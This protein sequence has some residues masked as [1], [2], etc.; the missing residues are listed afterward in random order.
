MDLDHI[1][2]IFFAKPERI[3]SR[4][5]SNFS[6]VLNLL[7]S[8]TPDEIR[9]I[10]DRSLANYQ[11]RKKQGKTSLWKEFTRHL[12]FLKAEG[13]VDE[14]NRLTEDGTWAS[15]LRLDQPLLIAQCLREDT[16]PRD[17][18]A[19]LAAVIAPFA[20]D[21]SSFATISRSSLPKRLKKAYGLCLSGFRI[22]LAK[23]WRMRDSR[24]RL[25]PSGDA[26]CDL[27]LGPGMDWTGLFSDRG[28]RMAILAMLISRT[29]DSLH[30]IASLTE[31][32]PQV[33]ARA[34]AARTAIPEIRSCLIDL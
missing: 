18:E 8:H 21:R 22:P 15:Q 11:Y 7:L 29:A 14:Q 17:S 33:S 30:Q 3:T 12:E 4:L 23:G 19:L 32:H 28:W 26:A 2:K 9:D 25:S 31:S 27:R 13:F 6:M 34:A 1:R 16:L 24:W 5:R 20:Y 10:F